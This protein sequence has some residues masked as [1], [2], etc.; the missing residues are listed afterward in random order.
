[1][2]RS[3]SLVRLKR[4]PCGIPVEYERWSKSSIYELDD[5]LIALNPGLYWEYQR[6]Y[7]SENT[8][9]S[10]GK[11]RETISILIACAGVQ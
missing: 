7:W 10:V 2:R 1:M 8:F 5:D 6:R 3:S 9:V 11:A 4:N